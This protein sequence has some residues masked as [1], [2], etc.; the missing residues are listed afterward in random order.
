MQ[1]SLSLPSSNCSPRNFQT[2]PLSCPPPRGHTPPPNPHSTVRKLEGPTAQTY[3]ITELLPSAQSSQTHLSSVGASSPGRQIFIV[4]QPSSSADPGVFL[5]MAQLNTKEQY[6]SGKETDLLLELIH[7]SSLGNISF[8][9]SP[10]NGW[11]L[12]WQGS[13]PERM[14][15]SI[16]EQQPEHQHSLLCL[17]WVFPG[18]KQ[19]ISANPSALGTGRAQPAALPRFTQPLWVQPLRKDEAVSQH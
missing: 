12:L 19:A 11:G 1:L 2:C 4:T 15:H 10:V 16:H 7:H 5:S 3:P 9:E 8:V 17:V 13:Q 6:P 18:L 14:D